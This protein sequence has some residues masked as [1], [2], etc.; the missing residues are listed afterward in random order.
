MGADFLLAMMPLDVEREEAVAR[1]AALTDDRFAELIADIPHGWGLDDEPGGMK[2]AIAELRTTAALAIDDLYAG[3][4]RDASSVLLSNRW[5]V[6]TG[7]M[8]W[9]D[10]PT[11]TYDDVELLCALRVT[12]D[13]WENGPEKPR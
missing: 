4:R 3:C 1:L 13:D 5:W 9:G 2:A 11:E 6:A 7:G 12:Y 10:R 8:S